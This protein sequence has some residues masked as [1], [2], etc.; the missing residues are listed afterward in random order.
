M[1]DL[2]LVIGNKNYSSWSLRP[3]M[4]M[5]HLGME[6]KELLLP[7]DTPEFRDGIEKY[8][9]SGRVPVLQ[10]GELRV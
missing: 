8:S 3:W 5:K 10:H 7:L 2:T 9:P 4:L 6:F 1:S